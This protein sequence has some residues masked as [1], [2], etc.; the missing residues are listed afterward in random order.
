MV[1]PLFNEAIHP[2]NR[3]QI[4]TILSESEAVDFATL[5][6]M[7]GISDSSLSKHIKY[8]MD[9]GYVSARKTRQGRHAQTWLSLTTPGIKAYRGH[10]AELHRILGDGA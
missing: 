4:C 7:L 2:R 10:I 9:V 3:L 1:K 6:D 5:R 8:L